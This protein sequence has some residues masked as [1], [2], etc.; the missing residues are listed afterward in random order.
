[1]P[2]SRMCCVEISNRKRS[3]QQRTLHIALGSGSGGAE[4]GVYPGLPSGWW[5]D[6]GSSHLRISPGAGVDLCS[7]VC[8]TGQG[9]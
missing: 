8:T 6:G 2:H 7:V 1:M 5:R 4:S 3:P 9:S